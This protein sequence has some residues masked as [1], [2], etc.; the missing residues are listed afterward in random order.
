MPTNPTTK[1]QVQAYRFVLRRMESALVRKDAMMLHEPMRNHL[2]AAAVG[3]ILGVLGLAAFFVVGLFKS[4][5]DIEVGDIVAVEGTTS[6]FVAVETDDERLSLVPVFN[7]T[8]ARLLVAALKPG[9]EPRETKTV[10]ESALDGIPRLPQIGLRDAPQD[11]PAPEKLLDGA[12][13][14]CDNATVR[15]ELPNA[16]FHP[17]LST[18][19]IVGGERGRRLGAD[20]ALLVEEDSDDGTYLLWTGQRLPVDLEDRAVRLAYELDGV[21]PR[22]VSTGLLNAIPQGSPLTPPDIR[23][24]GDPAPFPQLSDAGVQIGEVVQVNRAGQESF[25]LVLPDGKQPVQRAVADLIRF[26]HGTSLDFTEVTPE[27]IREVPDAPES[28]RKNFSDFPGQVPQVLAITAAPV[29]CLVRPRADADPVITVSTDEQ[30]LLDKGVAVP[31]AAGDQAD[32]VILAPGSG[33][34]VRGVLPDQRTDSGQLWLVTDQGFRYGVPSIEVARALRLGD[35]VA[36][37]PDSILKLLKEG[38]VLEPLDTLRL[39]S[40]EL[41]QQEA[42]RRAGR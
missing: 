10:E 8:S 30:L 11:L 2:Q 42:E 1:S 13:S 5:G 26:D 28:S 21:V 22:K 31:G 36:L 29:A 20:Q 23:G 4:T 16:E 37:A 34:L 24:A 33:A 19:V 9:A 17:E 40:P 27:D 6:V 7:V 18:T 35:K 3:L 15:E 39:Y 14:V 12:W 41:A 38:P 32:R 25:F